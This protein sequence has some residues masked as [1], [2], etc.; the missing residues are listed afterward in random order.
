MDMMQLNIW[1][2]R[3]FGDFLFYP[4][5]PQNT[6]EH[7]KVVNTLEILAMD[8][9]R[10]LD[11]DR[12]H[13]FNAFVNQAPVAVCGCDCATSFEELSDATRGILQSING[14]P[15]TRKKQS[16]FGYIAKSIQDSYHPTVWQEMIRQRAALPQPIQQDFE[17][18]KELWRALLTHSISFN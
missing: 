12:Q 11:Y 17:T 18:A 2:D 6:R 16:Y 4:R 9:E 7:A 10:S 14:N 8:E 15:S 3:D 13:A 5:H 1:E